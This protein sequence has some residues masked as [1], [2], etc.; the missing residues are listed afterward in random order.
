[1][2]ITTSTTKARTIAAGKAIAASKAKAAKAKGPTKAELARK[3]EERAIASSEKELARTTLEQAR[4]NFADVNVKEQQKC[5]TYAM[6]LNSMFAFILRDH[7]IHWSEVYNSGNAKHVD[8]NLRPIW[9]LI[10]A[11]YDAL[12][13]LMEGKHSNIAGVWKRAWEKAFAIAFP[14]KK[15]EPRNAKLPADSAMEKLISA[16]KT[17]AKETIQSERDER[18]ALVI[19]EALIALKVDIQK[20]N[21]K[22]G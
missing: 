8:S 17:V 2:T 21:Q 18:I 7:K 19:G 5:R 1:M 15:R 16:Y 13:A 14:G 3:Q 12:K 22:L 6:H 4:F 10:D 11:E 9:L 20:I